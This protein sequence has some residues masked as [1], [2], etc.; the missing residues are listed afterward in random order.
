MVFSS[1][2][3]IFFFLPVALGLYFLTP[4]RAKNAVLLAESLVFYTWGAGDLVA[5]LIFSIVCNFLFGRAIG[6]ARNAERMTRRN[7]L[8]TLDIL[9]N[10][11]LLAYYKYANFAV[12]QFDSL[13]RTAGFERIQWSPVVLLIG[14]SFFTFHGLSYCVDVARGRN[15]A[16]HN[17]IDFGLYMTL[18]PQLVA[19]PIIRYH[20]IADQFRSRTVGLADVSEGASRFMWGLA[21]KVVIA[22]AVAELANGAFDLAPG[23]RS[24]VA[25]WVGVLAYTVQIYFDFSGYSDMAIGLA[26]MFGFRF[27]ENFNRPYSAYSVTDFW[28]RWHITLSN[29]FRDYLY[30]PLGGNV[31][32]E[33]RTYTNLLIVFFATGLWHG[34]NW[35]FVIWG[36]Y[37]GAIMMIERAKGWRYISEAPRPWFN[38]TVTLLLVAVGWVMFRSPNIH[39]ALDFYRVMFNP[40][41]HVPTDLVSL[42][43]GRKN[44]LALLLGIGVF[45]LPRSLVVGRALECAEDR[46]VDPARLAVLCVV[47]PYVAMLVVSGTFS[48][49]LY[50]QF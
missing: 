14:I 20:E 26:R 28:R 31:G 40:F 45:F 33:A 24:F 11:A 30:I 47:L 6:R 21:K 42:G 46:W 22:D 12:A 25:A 48:P 8:L 38:R 13:W 32:S 35:T 44:L 49:F 2:Q 43:L 39:T 27:P 15:E 23:N 34:A 19:G 17:P 5:V 3:F 16:L 36:L 50:F 29:W 10:L 37:H 7:A 4:R 18:F 9:V 1:V 41:H